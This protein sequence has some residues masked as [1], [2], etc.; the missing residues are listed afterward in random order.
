MWSDI[1]SA[2]KDLDFKQLNEIIADTD[3]L[4]LLKN[5]YVIAVMVI[6]AIVFVVRGMEKALVT[7]ISV[8][9]IVVLFQY[10]VEGTNAMDF[11]PEKLIF[12]AGF[13]VIAA[14]NVYFFFVRGK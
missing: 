6:C 12:C 1:L 9:A 3:M 8:P 7:M 2:L 13:V 11:D 4:T 14:L 10:T 5:P